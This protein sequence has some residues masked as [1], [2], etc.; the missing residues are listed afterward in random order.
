MIVIVLVFVRSIV[1]H[2]SWL[3]RIVVLDRSVDCLVRRPI[4][5]GLTEPLVSIVC[6]LIL[7]LWSFDR[8]R[9]IVWPVA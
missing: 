2:H 6:S 4:A 1:R 5:F 7:D 9:S 3:C 8:S